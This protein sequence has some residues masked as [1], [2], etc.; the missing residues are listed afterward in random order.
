MA[1]AKAIEDLG[2]HEMASESKLPKEAAKE[3]DKRPGVQAN[4]QKAKDDQTGPKPHKTRSQN[5]SKHNNNTDQE[6]RAD[7]RRPRGPNKVTI[8]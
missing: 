1:T 5:T 8:K 3:E 7:K 4:V 2:D 6:P